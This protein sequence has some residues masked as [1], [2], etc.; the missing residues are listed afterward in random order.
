MQVAS[1]EIVCRH[2]NFADAAN[3]GRMR[4]AG[5]QWGSGFQ[6]SLVPMSCPSAFV[7]YCTQLI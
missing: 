4:E 1:A 7:R 3:V 6:L 2:S 5:E